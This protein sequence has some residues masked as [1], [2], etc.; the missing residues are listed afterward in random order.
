MRESH[1]SELLPRP[2]PTGLVP[3]VVF[4]LVK[5]A[6]AWRHLRHTHHFVVMSVLATGLYYYAY[7]AG[8]YRLDSG[9]AG[10]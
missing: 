5:R 8:T 7:A 4:A 6:F 10:A 1:S 9:I 3:V 2:W